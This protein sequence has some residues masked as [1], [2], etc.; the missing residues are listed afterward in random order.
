ML[1][2][3]GQDQSSEH[4][5]VGISGVF[6]YTQL[7]MTQGYFYPAD[8]AQTSLD[9]SAEGASVTSTACAC[10]PAD[11]T[12]TEEQRE[13][14]EADKSLESK[15]RGANMPLCHAE[16]PDVQSTE[17]ESDIEYTDI[18]DEMN[19]LEGE[20]KILTPGEYHSITLSN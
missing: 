9:D 18:A 6:I 14:Q 8:A 17:C 3:D 12:P 4:K 16:K 7:Y 2:Y 13:L 19:L 15:T 11:P 5:S 10:E 1:D 20:L